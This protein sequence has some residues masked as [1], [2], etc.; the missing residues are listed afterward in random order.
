MLPRLIAVADAAHA[1]DAATASVVE[2]ADGFAF[3]GA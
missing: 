1:V 3:L 2:P